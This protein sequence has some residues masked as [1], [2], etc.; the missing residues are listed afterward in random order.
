MSVLR[1]GLIYLSKARW[2]NGMMTHFFLA[3]RVARRF[4]AGET[5]AEAVAATRQ[6]NAQGLPAT[7]DVLGESVSHEDETHQVV[8]AYQ[9]VLKAIVEHKLDASVSLKLTQLGLDISEDLCVANLRLILTAA[10]DAGNVPLTIDM[11]SHEYVD[12][13][14][15]IYRTMRDEYAFDHVGT[16]IQSYLY[17]SDEDMA[18]LAAEGAHI[19]LVKGAYLEPADI[20]YPEKADVDKAFVRQTDAFLKAGK[21]TGAYLCVASHDENMLVAAIKSVEA[22]AIPNDRYEFQMLY[23]IRTQRQLELAQAGY[24]MRVYVPF[25]KAWYP[26]FMRRLAER[27]ANLWFFV[28]SLFAR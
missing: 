17:R 5:L 7:L 27:P 13:T 15:Q 25:G 28:K 14:L 24:K 21:A 10:R 19:R 1:R 11:E 6:L 23:G 20:A 3:R 16:V 2:A 12:R 8:A 4:V 9:D 18:A 22:H 26:Y